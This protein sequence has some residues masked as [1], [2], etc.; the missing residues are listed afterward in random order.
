MLNSPKEFTD[1][2][3]CCLKRN[4]TDEDLCGRLFLLRVLFLSGS[5]RL[6][7]VNKQDQFTEKQ[8][9]LNPI[10]LFET[11]SLNVFFSLIKFAKIT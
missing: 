9:F 2:F 7:V 1:F 11:I 6:S 5:G 8:Y 4:V 3:Q 10:F